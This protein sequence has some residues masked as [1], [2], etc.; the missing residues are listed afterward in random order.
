MAVA[1]AVLLLAV[2]AA[3]AP[4]VLTSGD[5]L[6]VAPADRLQAPSLDHPFGTD[7]LGRDVLTRVVHGTGASLTAALAAVGVAIAGGLVIGV[8]TGYLGGWAD[9]VGMRLVDVLLAVPA[10]L[11]SMTVIAATGGGTLVLGVAVGIA[12]VAGASR[13]LRARTQQLRSVPFVEAATVSGWRRPTVITRHILPHLW[14]T[15]AA[16]ASVEFG[17]AVLAVAALGF[18]GFGPPPPAPEWGAMVADGRA[19]LADSWWLTLAPAAV[20]TAV[21]LAAYRLSRV[22]GG[23]RA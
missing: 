11:L 9:R 23:S 21:V 14:P 7:Q 13:V 10:L 12:G 22:I 2:L 3:V 6:A 18:L 15:A 8:T 1:A 20:I 17:Q 16:V 5:P 19:F 4:G